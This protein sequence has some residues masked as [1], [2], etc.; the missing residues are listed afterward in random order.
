MTHPAKSDLEEL[1]AK[2]GIYFFKNARGATIYIGKARSL[3]DR[4]KSY[5]QLS[6]DPK[7]RN[8][9]AETT[10]LDYLLTG[11]EREAA[12]LE[13]NFIQ[14][15]QPKFNLRLKDDK[16]FPYLRVNIQNPVPGVY[17][18]RKISADGAR[19]FGPFSPA[20]EARK[21]IQILTKS[22]R[23]RT[24]E[25]AVYRGRK[26]PCLEYDLGL[27]SAP[28]VGLISAR[29]YQ[30]S[31]RNAILFLEGRTDELAASLREAMSAAAE[32]ERFEDA[33]RIRDLLRTIAQIRI[34][35]KT[36]S[37]RREN[38]DIVGCAQAGRAWAI[39]V[40]HMRDGK[41]RESREFAFEAGSE[42]SPAEV[43]GDFLESFYRDHPLPQKILVPF[44]RAE[45]CPSDDPTRPP[46]GQTGPV[47]VPRRGRGRTLIELA[48]KNAEI[49]LRRTQTGQA[50]LEELKSILGFST[51]PVRIDGFDVSHTQGLE[52]VASLVTFLNGRPWKDGYRRYRIKTVRGSNDVA[53]LSEAVG[54]R[55]TRLLREKRPLPDLVLVD[56][57]KPQ[58]EAARA[59]LETLGLSSLPLA[60][61]AKREEIIYTADRPDGVRLDRT[62]A[63]LKLI[64]YIRDEAHRFAVA[65]HRARRSKRSFA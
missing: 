51:L 4:V 47:L 58:L 15:T 48:S 24:C 52:T 64:Q 26:R 34:R 1:P 19:F 31:V 49:L 18:S 61:L 12:F 28:C 32:A 36:I 63:A 5:F 55:F 25:E 37:V 53:A 39:H 44:A 17:F 46:A 62:S 16:S 60:A 13:N 42:F 27:C 21:T 9:L 33:A 35:P 65:Y 23:L 2:P 8:I 10:R 43:I 20:R 57:G 22:F 11:S 41:V 50:P 54:R 40:F 45:S 30:D 29:A 3:A 56:G 59:V 6:D 7:V 38:W 14:Q